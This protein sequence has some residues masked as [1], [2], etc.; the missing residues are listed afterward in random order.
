[1]SFSWNT[2][3]EGEFRDIPEEVQAESAM[4]QF[5]IT[6]QNQTTLPAHVVSPSQPQS[7]YTEVLSDARLRL[8]QGRLY[9]MIM[10]HDLF[11]GLDSNP[12]AIKNV[13]REI[14][15]FAKERMEIMLGMR[16]PQ[17]TN[18]AFVELPFNSLEIDLLKQL[19]F[20]MSQGKTAGSTPTNS[21]TVPVV[22]KKEKLTPIIG[23][24][25][26]KRTL[27]KTTIS[28]PKSNKSLVTK[29][30]VS[31]DNYEPLKAPPGQLTEQE[32]IERN[33]QAIARQ[34]GKKAA[35]PQ[36]ALPQPTFEQQEM[37]YTQSA[38][39]AAP[40]VATIMSL[41]NASKKK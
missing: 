7:D 41:I 4:D 34:I 20:K 37:L 8:E 5:M 18:Q 1:M 14:R 25:S 31:T 17:P 26:Q 27:P 15:K 10:N 32:R 33:K 22:V 13:Q 21:T 12:Q 23:T 24:S 36:N 19:A 40:Q 38:I 30:E 6:S 35:K 9:E 2:D 28:A 16:Q 39:A 11:Q 3:Q 29:Q